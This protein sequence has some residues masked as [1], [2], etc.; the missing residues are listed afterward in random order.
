[1]TLQVAGPRRCE[2]RSAVG[3]VQRKTLGKTGVLRELDALYLLN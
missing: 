3:E 1:M 2:G